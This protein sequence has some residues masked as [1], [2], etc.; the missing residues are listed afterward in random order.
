MK[1]FRFLSLSTYAEDE[2]Q[3]DTCPVGNYEFNKAPTFAAFSTLF[4]YKLKIPGKLLR[5]YE[6]ETTPIKNS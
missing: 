1:A 3:V 2:S 6:F 4:D 5:M